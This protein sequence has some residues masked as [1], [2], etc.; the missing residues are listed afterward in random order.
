M[1]ENELC[2]LIKF[3]ILTRIVS[4]GFILATRIVSRQKTQRLVHTYLNLEY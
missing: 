3:N 4:G 1:D 2:P